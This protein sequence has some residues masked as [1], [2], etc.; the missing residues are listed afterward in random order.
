VSRKLYRVHRSNLAKELNLA[1]QVL[2]AWG[3]CLGLL[4][5]DYSSFTWLSFGDGSEW[6]T[7]TSH[8]ASRYQ[9]WKWWAVTFHSTLAS[10]SFSWSGDCNARTVFLDKDNNLKLGDFGLS[11]A[12]QQA[13][14]TQ[15]YVGVRIPS[16][17]LLDLLGWGAMRRTDTLL[18]V[19]GTH[20]RTTLRRQIWYLGTRMF[21]LRALRWTV[22]FAFLHHVLIEINVDASPHLIALLSTKRERNLNWQSWFEKGRFQIYRKPTRL[23]SVKSFEL[24]WNRTWVDKILILCYFKGAH[25]ILTIAQPKH[26][27]NTSQIKALDTVRLQIRA[28]ELR[29]A[30]VP[31][32]ALLLDD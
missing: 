7:E 14:M 15:T 18:H 8:L 23:I 11:K 3:C 2:I 25:Q 28:L 1:S 21:D 19:T 16:L 4:D 13:A 31:Y 20:Q 17:H 27:P 12:M 29:K 26:R 9:T 10:S 24:C 32:A 6:E 22:S 30:W 5:P